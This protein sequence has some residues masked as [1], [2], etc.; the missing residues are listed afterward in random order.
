MVMNYHHIQSLVLC[1]C[2]KISLQYHWAGYEQYRLKKIPC[3]QQM[4]RTIKDLWYAGY[5][6]GSKSIE[7]PLDTG[8]PSRVIRY[9]L[10]N[11]VNQNFIAQECQSL[12]K[13]LE[14][15]KF[16][17]NLFGNPFDYGLCTDGVKLITGK[18]KAMLHKTHPDKQPGFNKQFNQMTQCMAWIREGVP[19]PTDD[20]NSVISQNSGKLLS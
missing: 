4:H 1:T 7:E 10:V 2:W 16:G 11:E 8:L 17:V 9:Q 13:K 15:A 14:R 3:K 5:I 6:V 19:L 12:Y 18:V 20:I